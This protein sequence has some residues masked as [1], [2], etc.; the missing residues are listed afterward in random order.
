MGGGKVDSVLS[1]IRAKLSDFCQKLVAIPDCNFW[2]HKNQIVAY[3][4]LPQGRNHRPSN[5]LSVVIACLKKG[6]GKNQRKNVVVATGVP[7]MDLSVTS[8]RKC[9]QFNGRQEDFPGGILSDTAVSKTPRC[10]K[11]GNGSVI[12]VKEQMQIG[13]EI[14]GSMPVNENDALLSERVPRKTTSPGGKNTL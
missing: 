7:A 3:L 1:L 2:I 9:F 12:D 4:R 13:R 8:N 5:V 14:M 11:F 10:F 6:Y